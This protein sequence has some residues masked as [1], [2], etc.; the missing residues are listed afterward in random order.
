MNAI[1]PVSYIIVAGLKLRVRIRFEAP[2]AREVDDIVILEM[3]PEV[4]VMNCWIL[5]AKGEVPHP[6]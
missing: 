6:T 3:V 2:T 5:G 1:S 4:N